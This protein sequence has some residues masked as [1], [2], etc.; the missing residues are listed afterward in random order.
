MDALTINE[1][2]DIIV[3]RIKSKE[4]TRHTVV[5]VA[6]LVSI[7]NDKEL[8]D[9]VMACDLIN[10]D[11]MGVVWGGRILGHHIPERVTGID[12]FYRLLQASAIEKFPVFLLGA[13][14]D[15]VITTQKNIENLYPEIMIAGSHHGYFGLDEE[16]N[17]VQT[18]QKSGAKLLFVAISSPTKEIFINKWKNEL[19]IHFVMGVGGTFDVVAGK[20]KRAPLLVQKMGLEWL[21]RLFQEPRRMWKRYIFT[22]F[23]YIV[24]LGKEIIS[25][26]FRQSK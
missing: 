14:K 19:G 1:T 6:K 26:I 4:F 15:V 8:R 5:N 13:T 3:G 12:L 24:L 7:R 11:G 22:N 2:V 9:A 17:I 18:I 25:V 10:I 23:F 16:K 21:Y 20:V